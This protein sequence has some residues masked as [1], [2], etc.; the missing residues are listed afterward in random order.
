VAPVDGRRSVVEVAQL[1]ESLNA[2]AGAAHQ[3]NWHFSVLISAT[4]LARFVRTGV[5][6]ELRTLGS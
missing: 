1:G 4:F 2:A 6:W 5:Y 3:L